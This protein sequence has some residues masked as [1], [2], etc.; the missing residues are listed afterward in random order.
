MSRSRSE[1]T[2]KNRPKIIELDISGSEKFELEKSNLGESKPDNSKSGNPGPNSGS[3]TWE[4]KIIRLLIPWRKELIG[5]L[6]FIGAAITL[7]AYSGLT[8]STIVDPWTNA[9]RQLVGWGVV[10]IAATIALVGLFFI[11]QKAKLPF[12]LTIGQI[13][14][15]ELLI[16]IWLALSHMVYGDGLSGALKGQGGGIIGW[17]LSDPLLDYVGPILMMLILTGL[18]SIGLALS[19]KVGWRDLID[20][21]NRTSLRFQIWSSEL[22]IDIAERRASREPAVQDGSTTGDS[23]LESEIA[24]G[25]TAP[26]LLVIYEESLGLTEE[27]LVR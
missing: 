2:R 15:L 1:E 24:V 5:G 21:L 12:R 6:L 10:P 11:F 25:T 13:I 8:G 27:P 14:G 23:S 9:L 17:A 3:A 16:L 4:E 26:E 22:D 20:S 18:F 19:F 7:L